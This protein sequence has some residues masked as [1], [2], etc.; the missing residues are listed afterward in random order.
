[1]IAIIGLPFA[2][3]GSVWLPNVRGSDGHK[4]TARQ[5]LQRLDIPGCILMFS[6]MV[7]LVLGLMFR[8]IYGLKTAKFLVSV[9][10][11]WPLFVT[12]LYYQAQLPEGYASMPP[13]T[14]PIP[15]LI[16]Y[17][18]LWLLG[19]KPAGSRPAMESRVQQDPTRHSDAN[20]PSRGFRLSRSLCCPVSCPISKTFC[21]NSGALGQGLTKSRG[22]L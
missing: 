17:Q 21:Q 12:F 20:G 10:L 22:R 14:W 13:S 6:A 11:S 9:L 18:G 5:K 16:L 19:Y 3:T 8:A 2:I 15:N 1:M 4:Y 7:L